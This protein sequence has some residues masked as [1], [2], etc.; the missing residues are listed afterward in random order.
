VAVNEVWD[1]GQNCNL[2][3][4]IWSAA[5]YRRFMLTG[6]QSPAYESDIEMSHSKLLRF[7]V[8]AVQHF[9]IFIMYL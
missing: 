7:F 3:K 4:R 9:E 1:E 5:I 6:N 8:A 2:T